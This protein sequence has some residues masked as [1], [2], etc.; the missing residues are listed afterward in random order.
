MVPTAAVR[1]TTIPG[2]TVGLEV[3]VA[4]PPRQRMTAH[5][6]YLRVMMPERKR[7]LL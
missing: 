1:M 3:M 6:V 4:W 7:V 5:Q 2:A